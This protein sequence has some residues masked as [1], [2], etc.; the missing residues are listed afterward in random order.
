LRFEIF[1]CKNFKKNLIRKNNLILGIALSVVML[2]SM[3]EVKKEKVT[4]QAVAAASDYWGWS[5]TTSYVVG[6]I[7]TYGGYVAGGYFGG[8]WGARAGG[9]VGGL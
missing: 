8:I 3:R 2:V 7:A 4:V 6:A 1:F 5:N 9:F